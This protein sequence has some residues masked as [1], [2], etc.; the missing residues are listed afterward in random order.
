L[1]ISELEQKTMKELYALAREL[2]LT[3]YS[4]LRK[5]ELIFEILKAQIEKDGH[6]FAQGVL[7][8]MPE[9]FGFLRPVN[10][11]P[12]NDDIYVS[13]SQIRRFDLRMGDFISG[14]ARPPKDNERYFALLRIEA[15]NGINP[16]AAKERLHF[17]GLTPVFPQERLTL[18]TRDG[19]ISRR[20]I[21]L[22]APIGKGQRGLIVSPPK[23]GKT[24][25]LKKIANGITENH[26]DV[27]LMVLLIDE[28][29][30]EVTDME[31]SVQGEV[32][33]STF[34]RRPRTMSS[35]PIWSLNGPNAW[36]STGRT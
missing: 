24:V 33:S 1:D 23:A 20:L 14:Q 8:I 9:G 7:D 4:D 18:E 30:E 13:P 26:P 5:K 16:E 28:R 6:L 15:V 35:W 32:L 36:W 10:Y 11:L 31:R 29:P 34:A 17:Q 21:D 12:S 2:N 27:V 3:G 25:L 19:D 22:I